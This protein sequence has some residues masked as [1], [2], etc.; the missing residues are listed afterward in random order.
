MSIRDY[1]N[2]I[3]NSN[4]LRY[5]PKKTL[6]NMYSKTLI[7]VKRRMWKKVVLGAAVNEQTIRKSRKSTNQRLCKVDAHP[8]DTSTPRAEKFQTCA[9]PTQ[10]Y[11]FKN[12]I[13]EDDILRSKIKQYI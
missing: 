4:I 11:F 3:E 13:Y 2:S 12:N 9:W 6:G 8:P 5:K 7:A 10:S 1:R